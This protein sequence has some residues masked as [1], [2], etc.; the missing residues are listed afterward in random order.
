[1]EP[2]WLLSSVNPSGLFQINQQKIFIQRPQDPRDYQDSCEWVESG[3][4]TLCKSWSL[5]IN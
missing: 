3:L 2:L 5:G 1:M 4:P